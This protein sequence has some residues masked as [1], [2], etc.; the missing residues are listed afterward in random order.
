MTNLWIRNKF[1]IINDDLLF[2]Y[3]KISLVE[4]IKEE[5][6]N[7]LVFNMGIRIKEYCKIALIFVLES[8]ADNKSD[9]EYYTSCMKSILE[10]ISE[11]ELFRTQSRITNL[12]TQN[13]NGN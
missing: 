1:E 8:F 13:L 6:I 10:N 9:L 7:N 2:A 11:K 4:D 5:L 3:I 12:R